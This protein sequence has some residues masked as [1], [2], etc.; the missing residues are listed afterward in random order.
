VR[1]P[2]RIIDEYLVACARLGDKAAREQLVMRYQR[3]FLVHAYRLLGNAEQARDAVQEGWIDILRG[4]TK[5]RDDSMFAAWSHR[6][7]TRK[8]YGEIK[9]AQKNREMLRAVKQE[10]VTREIGGDATG[11][12]S[13]RQLVDGALA[14]LSPE[15]RAAVSMFYLKDMSVAEI[16]VSLDIPAGTVKTRLMSA[17]A[18][19]RAALQGER[20]GQA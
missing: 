11:K 13:D 10:P 12:L 5:L 8:C 19:M 1:T 9:K 16:A 2:K 4:L 20:D 7:I 3:Q 15:Q 17:R 14:G 18:K 6:I